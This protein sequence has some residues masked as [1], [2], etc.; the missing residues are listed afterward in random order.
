MTKRNWTTVGDGVVSRERIERAIASL[1]WQAIPVELGA[2]QGLGI[3]H[4]IREL[5]IP[6]VSHVA[7]TNMLAPFCFYGIRGHYTN[8]DADVFIID[9]GSD[10][11]PVC[12]DFTEK[13]PA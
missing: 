8:G 11:I 2:G 10:L 7:T 4:A 3:K 1:E 6:K 9:R 5:R 12:S 13:V